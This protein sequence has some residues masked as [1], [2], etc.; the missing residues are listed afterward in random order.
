MISEAIKKSHLYLW[1]TA[2]FK[3]PRLRLS[4]SLS[5]AYR[6]HYGLWM[7]G[8][9]EHTWLWQTGL[10]HSG[11]LWT[12]I[13]AWIDVF[14]FW[15]SCLAIAEKEGIRS[16]LSNSKRRA[17]NWALGQVRGQCA[18]K[19]VLPIIDTTCQ[20]VHRT[21]KSASPPTYLPITK[22]V[23]GHA[24]FPLFQTKNASFVLWS[25]Q[26]CYFNLCDYQHT[27]SVRFS[28]T[29]SRVLLWTSNSEVEFN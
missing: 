14:T 6:H 28:H 12:I 4:H 7:L 21:N 24:V 15:F 13:T 5:L 20:C 10:M 17:G 8:C 25:C 16:A 18:R 11:G 23:C 19:T 22:Y 1:Y 26:C 2:C 3:F 9:S 29:N 27:I